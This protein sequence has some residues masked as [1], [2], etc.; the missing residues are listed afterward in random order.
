MI[1]SILLCGGVGTRLWPI[2]TDDTPKQ[3]H[4]LTNLQDNDDYLIQNTMNRLPKDS[5][6]IFASNIKYKSYIQK[7][8]CANDTIICEPTPKSTAPIILLSC[9]HILK[10]NPEVDPKTIKL[11]ISPCDHVFDN[12]KF[13]IKID[14]ALGLVENY[15]VTFGIKPTYPECSYGYIKKKKNN[16]IDKFI[17][18]PTVE[19]A[20]K[21]INDDSYYW[22]SGIFVCN[23][24]MIIDKYIKHAHD[25]Y[26]TCVN[27]Y[28]QSSFDN[29]NN[30]V[31]V[32]ESYNYCP[33]ISFD[34][35][36]MEP[37][38]DSHS[39]STTSKDV[40]HLKK[41]YVIEFDGLWSDIG[42]WDRIHQICNKDAQENTI[43]GNNV[44]I[45]NSSNC[46]VNIDYGTIIL[47]GI[48]DLII[49]KNKDVIMICN[50]NNIDDIKKIKDQ[51]DI[52]N[53]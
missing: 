51:L 25:L 28:N 7:Y 27:C 23:L 52:K 22:N 21:L 14:E 15:I 16:T 26:Q 39:F 30:V 41:G 37:Q 2:S 34:Y 18:K 32:S 19:I 45:F 13:K 10:M 17:E 38:N 44:T 47:N 40:K 9:L 1:Y 29:N 4:K 33:N 31:N 6:K 3:F 8:L 12:D 50:K 43:I 48:S 35:A 36:I 20:K 5:I 24:E 42:Q 46:Y 49:V 53:E 11:I